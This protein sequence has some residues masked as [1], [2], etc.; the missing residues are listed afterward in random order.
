MVTGSMN[1]SSVTICPLPPQTGQPPLLL[2]EKR[3]A[4]TPFSAAI[5]LRISSK[6]PRQVAGVERPVA[7]T[8]DWST[9]TTRS[10]YCLANTS[11]MRELLPEPATPVTTVSTFSGMSTDTFFKLW[12]QAFRTGRKAF[13]IRGASFSGMTCFMASPVLV[14]D[15]SSASKLP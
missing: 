7:V 3:E 5:T 13:G 11:R 14:P 12:T 6:K 4:S 9:S 1:T 10:E 2:K 15:K 8:G